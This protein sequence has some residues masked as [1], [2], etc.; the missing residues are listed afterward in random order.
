M[1]DIVAKKNLKAKGQAFIVYDN[2]DSARNAVEESHGFELFGKPLRAAVAKSPS[3]KLVEIKCNDEEV[4]LHKRH[5]QAEKGTCLIGAS[6]RSIELIQDYR[7]AQSARGG[8]TAKPTQEGTRCNDRSSTGKG[9]SPLR[10]QVHKRRSWR[11]HPRR[12]PT[13]QQDSL[14]PER[15]RGVRHRSTVERFWPL[16]W[17]PRGS[18][19]AWSQGNR[20]CRVR[21]RAGRH[22]GQGEHC[23]H[24]PRRQAAQG[25]VSKAIVYLRAGLCILGSVFFT[26][27]ACIASSPN[28]RIHVIGRD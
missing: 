26:P 23:G 12:V 24:E 15:T 4:E 27:R 8:R 1:V 7:Q 14:H 5:R 16:R 13:A 25:Y 9:R 21:C 18:S 11:R 19:G 22:H 10:P 6:E 3:D 20:L 28:L 2:P 17:V